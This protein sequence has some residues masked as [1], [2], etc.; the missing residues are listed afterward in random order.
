[1][2]T[3]KV[4]LEGGEVVTLKGENKAKLESLVS[5]LPQSE[6]QAINWKF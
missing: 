2:I 6:I 1:L 5:L 4:T 3:C